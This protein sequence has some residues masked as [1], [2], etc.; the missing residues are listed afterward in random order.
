MPTFK[1]K[2]LQTDPTI[3]YGCT[4]PYSD[5]PRASKWDERASVASSSTTRDNP[6]NTYTHEGLPPGPISNP[7]RAALEAVLAP[8][9]TP[10][11]YFVARNDGTT[12]SGVLV[13]TNRML[14][15]VTASQ[16]ASA[17]VA[18]FFCRL[19]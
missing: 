5:R 9:D 1:P 19:T 16:M 6:Y 7:G 18:S 15:L 12:S 10:F 11:L 17:S 13:R 2:L 8:D 3:S 14:A 4:V